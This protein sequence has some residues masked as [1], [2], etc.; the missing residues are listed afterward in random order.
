MSFRDVWR[1]TGDFAFDDDI[2][3]LEIPMIENIGVEGRSIFEEPL[4]IHPV[5]DSSQALE[6]FSI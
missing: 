4:L 3:R 5:T 6:H 1:G 2:A